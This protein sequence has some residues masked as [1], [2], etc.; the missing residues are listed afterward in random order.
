[1]A[2]KHGKKK[3]R[4]Y[5]IWLNMKNRCHNP[6]TPRFKDYGGRGITVC[7]E[8]KDNFQAFY[9]WAMANGYSDDLTIDRKD[10]DKGYSPDNCRWT[11]N[12]I[13]GNNSRHNHTVT[14]QGKTQSLSD[15][16]RTL[17]VSFHLLS[18]RINHYGWSVERAFTTPKGNQGRRKL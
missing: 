17:G 6:R 18:N 16:A 10:N 11:T 15:W 8:W 4:L 14:Y 2:Y 5:R 7:D 3:T 12:L 13:Q 1:M 9:D